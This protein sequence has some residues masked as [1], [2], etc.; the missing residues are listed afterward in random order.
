MPGARESPAPS[1]PC[2]RGGGD[3]V[4]PRVPPPPGGAVL[5]E[6]QVPRKNDPGPGTEAPHPFHAPSASGSFFLDHGV[7]ESDLG[8]CGVELG[9]GG[10]GTWVV[11]GDC[12]GDS[13]PG[14]SLGLSS[15]TASLSYDFSL[16]SLLGILMVS[17]LI[18]RFTT[19]GSSIGACV[20]AT[21]IC[22][23]PLSSLLASCSY[24]PSASDP[25]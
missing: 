15:L 10:E 18:T 2:C 19:P 3:R 20:V 8:G 7:G 21:G 9:V 14:D 16:T 5:R 4:P 17:D 13:R 25:A 24:V 12:W 6:G 22:L 11:P 1:S 23:L